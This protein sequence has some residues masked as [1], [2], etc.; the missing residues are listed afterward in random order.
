MSK[1]KCTYE[2]HP[3]IIGKIWHFLI[4]EDS[5]LSFFVAA[6]LII[7]IGKFLFY[8]AI[9]IVFGTKF[10]VVAV[11]SNSMNH[12]GKDFDTWWNIHENQYKGYNLTKSDFE[13]YRFKNGFNKGDV[14]VVMG[15]D[16][17]KIKKGDTVVYITSER[18]DPIIHRTVKADGTKITT[19]GDANASPIGFERDMS[20]GKIKGVAVLKIPYLGWIKVGLVDLINKL[21]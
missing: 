6:I 3:S 7:L 12:Q 11:V 19:K 20:N 1:K 17:S 5:W 14:L 4:H 15:R 9:G 13:Q 18:S 10:P 21:R 2:T 8:P 16:I